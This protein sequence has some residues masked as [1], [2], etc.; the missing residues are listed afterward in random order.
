DVTPDSLVTVSVQVQD[1][2]GTPNVLDTTY[3]FTAG[4]ASVTV[5]AAD[6]VGENGG[7]VTC[8]TSDIS[9]TIPAGALQTEEEIQI[10]I[11]DNLPP[12]PDSISGFGLVYH[13]GPAG[14]QFADSVTI[15]IPYTQAML[16]E[17]GVTDPEDLPVYYFVTTTGEW[18]LLEIIG[19]DNTCIQVTVNQFCYLVTG[20]ITIIETLTVPGAPTG[21]TAVYVDSLYQ[22]STNGAVSNLGSPVEYCFS[23]GDGFSTTW[24]EDTGTAHAW[25]TAGTYTVTVTARVETNTG[26][27][28]TSQGLTVEVA[29]KPGTGVENT[30][31]ILPNNFALLQNHP[32]PFNPETSITYALPKAAQVKITVYNLMGQP[33]RTL[34][35][36]KVSAGTHEVIWNAKNDSGQPVPTGMYIY[37]LKCDAYTKMRKMLLMK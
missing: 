18:M 23:W 2:A 33:V 16:D 29:E 21:P 14:L 7:T 3:S 24:S 30:Q 5:I 37:L 20:S 17:A 9:V 15:S 25:N 26:L 35:N 6:S 28:H 10:G 22:Y 19:H 4:S 31:E 32:N 1:L 12:L 11:I 13:F 8:D 27:Q 36:T 34:V